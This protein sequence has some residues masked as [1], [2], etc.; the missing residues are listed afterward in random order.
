MY[1]GLEMLQMPTNGQRVY[2]FS[3][4]NKDVRSLVKNNKSH[5]LYDDQWADNHLYDVVAYNEEDARHL[6]IEQ[7]P[8]DEGFVINDIV[9]TNL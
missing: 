9:Q 1:G 2:E 5:R 4:Y 8:L 6:I 3:I 7:Y